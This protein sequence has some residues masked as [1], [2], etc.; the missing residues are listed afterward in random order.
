MIETKTYIYGKHAVAEAL[1]HAPHIINHLY[2][3]ELSSDSNLREMA[4]K[5]NVSMT[6]YRRGGMPKALEKEVG[7]DAA[8]Q[9]IV[10]NISPQK[11]MKPFKEFAQNLEATPDTLIAL[12]GEVQ[13][14]QNVG[15][16]IR[17]AAAFGAAAVLIPEHDQAQLSGA[18]IKVSA[19]MAF[20]MPLISVPNTNHALR[21]LKYKG[22]WV[23]GLEEDGR[24]RLSKEIFDRATVFVL[25][26][27]AEGIRQKTRE[28]C[29]I[30]LSIPMDPR[31]E[32]LNVAASAAVTLYA[33]S[34]QH[35]P[36]IS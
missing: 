29:D 30:M 10:A 14:P 24:Q 21:E 3:S 2:V 36:K 20:R 1:Q 16:I 6:E 9:G 22:F 5:N 4:R 25:G 35:P 17:S 31:C 11:L 26:N 15:A 8:H 12:L 27:E 23:Y 18:V 34:A 19:G 33:W 13:D 7:E 28:L 32:S